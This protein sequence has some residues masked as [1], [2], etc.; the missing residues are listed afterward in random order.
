M[1]HTGRHNERSYQTNR[2]KNLIFF[3]QRDE[4]RN[5]KGRKSGLYYVC[6]CVWKNLLCCFRNSSLHVTKKKLSKLNRQIIIIKSKST[7]QL[8][9]YSILLSNLHGYKITIAQS[10]YFSNFNLVKENI[11]TIK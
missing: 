2:S 1:I 6:Q 4:L 3:F 10:G 11:L 7:S 8:L 5:H 9:I